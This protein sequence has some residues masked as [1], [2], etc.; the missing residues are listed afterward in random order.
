MFA[1]K[2]HIKS[3][4]NS[5]IPV[6]F[7]LS[8]TLHLLYA[9]HHLNLP[10]MHFSPAPCSQGRTTVHSAVNPKTAPFVF[11]PTDFELS[12]FVTPAECRNIVAPH[13]LCDWFND[14]V[15]VKYRNWKNAPRAPPALS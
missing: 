1:Q 14:Q 10:G 15:T 11:Y 5:I 13:S 8:A 9:P 12:G 7:L 4:I 3:L 6:C 2:Q